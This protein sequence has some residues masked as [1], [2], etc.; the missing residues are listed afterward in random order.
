M[1]IHVC[2]GPGNAYHLERSVSEISLI[3]AHDRCLFEITVQ[4]TGHNF[5]RMVLHMAHIMLINRHQ[6]MQ[7]NLK[8]EQELMIEI[9]HVYHDSQASDRGQELSMNNPGTLLRV[10][11]GSFQ[12]GICRKAATTPRHSTRL[13]E[14]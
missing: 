3:N 2:K 13:T 6:S 12:V 9:Q 11:A 5:K 1:G 8:S 14:Q 7:R 4:T 10:N